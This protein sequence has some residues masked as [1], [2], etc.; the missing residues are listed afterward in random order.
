MRQVPREIRPRLNLR[1]V[2]TAGSLGPHHP[3]PLSAASVTRCRR[4]DSASCRYARHG[5]PAFCHCAAFFSTALNTKAC[6]QSFFSVKTEAACQSLA[7]IGGKSYGGS[8][9]VTSLPSGCFW[10]TVG[11]GVYLNTY[12]D[13]K[14]HPNAQQ[15]CAGGAP[16]PRAH[17]DTRT[18]ACTRMQGPMQMRRRQRSA[19]SAVRP[20]ILDAPR[21]AARMARTA[22]PHDLCCAYLRCYFKGSH[23]VACGTLC[24]IR[25]RRPKQQRLP[26]KLLFGH[27]RGGVQEPGGHCEREI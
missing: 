26:R 19:L 6:P 17:G 5:Q 22:L 24:S 13:G 18:H 9:N 10:L 21:N 25:D 20:L 11:G 1:M 23:A 14:A 12:A 3:L 27:N 4:R 2:R 16:T 15:L 8:V 7:A